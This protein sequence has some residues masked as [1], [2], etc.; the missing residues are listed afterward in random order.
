MKKSSNP[1]KIT[2]KVA[3]ELAAVSAIMMGAGA[4]ANAAP[5]TTTTQSGSTATSSSYYYY[6][7]ASSAKYYYY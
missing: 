3:A 6:A 1:V 5:T 2:V 4:F 7:P